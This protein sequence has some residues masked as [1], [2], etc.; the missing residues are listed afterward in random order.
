M[1]VTAQGAGS[2]GA[3]IKGAISLR[4]RPESLTDT[5]YEAIKQAIVDGRLP[6]D[7]RVTEAGLA[8]QLV[9]SKTPVREALLRLKEIGLVESDGPKVGRIVRPSWER[10]RDAYEV[11]EA[12][13]AA[14]ARAAAERGDRSLLSAARERAVATLEAAESGDLDR[15][16]RSDEAFHRIVA[17]AGGNYRLERLIDDTNV[18]VRVL[19]QRS[20][21]GLG[22]SESCAR[23][24]IAVA[25]AL[26]DGAAA[27]AASLMARHVREVRDALLGPMAELA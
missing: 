20:S 17:K 18:L 8:R 4:R 19:R 25:D 7:G 6:A 10:L 26:L 21:T 13:E 16:Q 23:G 14:S 1:A 2:D 5:V 3:A 9:V 12:L 24:H 27:D 15:Y 22:A 11:R